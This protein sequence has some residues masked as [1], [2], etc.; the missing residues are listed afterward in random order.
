MVEWSIGREEVAREQPAQLRSPVAGR[1]GEATQ[2]QADRLFD[3]HILALLP[4]H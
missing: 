1:G 3:H 2:D 4:S